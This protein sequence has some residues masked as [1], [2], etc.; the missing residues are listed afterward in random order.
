M[1]IAEIVANLHTLPF[2]RLY[3]KEFYLQIFRRALLV[4]K[5]IS[6]KFLYTVKIDWEMKQNVKIKLSKLNLLL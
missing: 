1:I 6:S 3:L 2:K 5:L 4:Q